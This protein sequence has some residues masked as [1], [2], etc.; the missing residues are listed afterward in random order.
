MLAGMRSI[1]FIYSLIALWLAFFG[2][3][4]IGVSDTLFSP[5]RDSNSPP[6]S[7]IE[8]YLIRPTKGH[9][10]YVIPV[11]TGSTLFQELELYKQKI[12][13]HPELSQVISDEILEQFKL[14][15][16]K[17]LL[18]DG[19]HNSATKEIA[20]QPTKQ[21]HRVL[22]LANRGYDLAQP[23]Q[24]LGLGRI[25]NLNEKLENSIEKVILPVGAAINLSDKE[26]NNFYKK[27]SQQFGG[28]IALGGADID[29]QLYSEKQVHSRDI[30]ASRDR[31]EIDF[32]KF[33]IK[34]SSGFLFGIC[35]G[36]QL[37]ATALG[38]KLQQHIDHHGDGQWLQHKVY[39]Q[40]TKTPNIFQQIFNKDMTSFPVLSYHHQ[41]VLYDP[42]VNTTIEVAAT[43][44]DGT[45]EALMSQDGRIFTTQFHPELRSD[46]ISKKIFGFLNV[47]FR[48]SPSLNKNKCLNLFR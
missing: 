22:I 12:K 16:S 18:T 32:L 4:S 23:P 34:N 25:G 36:H 47:K 11:R 17:K 45:V 5:S 39:V 3:C 21:T 10:N 14:G 6:N 7:Q 41:A 43:A 42:T 13:A 33:W 26:K 35:R 27:L 31:N 29:P 37:I 20:L 46:Y 2:T 9:L 1:S 15:T 24:T 40:P 38:Y 8:L 19:E 28:V 48:Q 30:N 44:Q